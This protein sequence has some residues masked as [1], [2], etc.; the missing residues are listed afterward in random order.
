[1]YGPA[2]SSCQLHPDGK[3]I[4]STEVP[5]DGKDSIHDVFNRTYVELYS[6][7][8][9]AVA[10]KMLMCQATQVRDCCT[11]SV[12]RGCILGYVLD[13][14]RAQVIQ[15]TVDDVHDGQGPGQDRD[16]W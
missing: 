12:S 11:C 15:E 14:R 9:R 8:V 16:D 2:N 3:P 13:D 7:V 1:M 5:V 10:I 6:G 4:A